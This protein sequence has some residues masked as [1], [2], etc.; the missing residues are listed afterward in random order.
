M[1]KSRQAN[2]GRFSNNGL[3]GTCHFWERISK[4]LVVSY[5]Y[6]ILFTVVRKLCRENI[7][8]SL[9]T[10]L[11]TQTSWSSDPLAQHAGHLVM[12]HK[13]PHAMCSLKTP[14]HENIWARAKSPPLAWSYLILF[15]PVIFITNI[16]HRSCSFQAFRIWW[17]T[18]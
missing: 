11:W 9:R 2:F 1:I 15:R 13:C 18:F 7:C 17:W 8:F 4:W 6:V 3:N 16:P 12:S 5:K 14:D 10:L